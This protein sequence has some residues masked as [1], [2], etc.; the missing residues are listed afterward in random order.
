MSFV[1]AFTGGVLSRV[2]AGPPFDSGNDAP[3]NGPSDLRAGAD[4]LDR[5]SPS[6]TAPSRRRGNACA[7]CLADR[8]G[9]I[10]PRE[11][12]VAGERRH[13]CRRERRCIERANAAVEDQ[14]CVSGRRADRAREPPARVPSVVEREERC[15]TSARE[16]SVPPYGPAGPRDAVSLRAAG[17]RGVAGGSGRR[18]RRGRGLRRVA[19]RTMAGCRGT[20]AH[21]RRARSASSSVS[22]RTAIS[23]SFTPAGSRS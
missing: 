15:V 18:S 3:T 2:S 9:H 4:S 17:G 6:S 1:S 7:R 21:S 16:S 14:A 12:D 13:A 10:R 19:A 8:P 22:S 23:P 20:T 11:R 5:R